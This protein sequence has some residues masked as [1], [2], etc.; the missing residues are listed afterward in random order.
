MEYKNMPL[1][2]DLSLPDERDF[3]LDLLETAA[4]DLPEEFYLPYPGKI[5][6]QKNI[7][8][9]AGATMAAERGGTEY[10]Q[11]GEFIEFSMGFSYA[12]R[13]GCI[14]GLF[15]L[16]GRNFRDLFKNTQR[17]G[18]VPQKDFPYLDTYPNLWK[19]LSADKENLYKK[20]EPF[21]IGAYFNI[22]VDAEDR[23]LQI[24][25]A[26]LNRWRVPIGV[27]IYESFYRTGKNGIVP[28]PDKEK[29]K[30]YG[31][32]AMKCRGYKP[33]YL[34]V[35]NSWDNSWGENGMCWI[36]FDFPFKELWIVTDDVDRYEVEVKRM[37]QD[38]DKISAWARKAVTEAFEL[39]LMKGDGKNFN[40]KDPVT[41]E[42]MAQ[43]SVN[44]YHK[45]MADI[46]KG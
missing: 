43:V 22:P 15:G 14:D 35:Q 30:M 38:G 3:T 46:Q 2:L 1:G 6:N 25:K 26:I 45:I 44:I 23:I 9:C 21:R 16:E 42:Q 27:P 29:E 40:P 10:E 31:Y 11:T 5:L 12:N 39:D 24:K 36:P 41:R 34:W 17:I 33:G 20:A 7:G 4:V 32:H 18:A 8:A 19:L 28:I 37:Y 13:E